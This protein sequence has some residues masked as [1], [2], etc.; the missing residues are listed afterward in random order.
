MKIEA[1]A[2]SYNFTGH[3]TTKFDDIINNAIQ[4]KKKLL[5]KALVESSVCQTLFVWRK[6][7]HI[8]K[9]NSLTNSRITHNQN[10][11]SM[12]VL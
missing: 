3:V 11:T 1:L 12:R 10:N 2:W 6:L 9:L 5:Q 7:D 4:V 8:F